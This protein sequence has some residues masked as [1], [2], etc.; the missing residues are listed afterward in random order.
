MHLVH[1]YFNGWRFAGND[2]KRNE[3][4]DGTCVSIEVDADT[5][6]MGVLVP[7]LPD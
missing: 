5:L 3:L 4:I 1:V 6:L 2:V 7:F